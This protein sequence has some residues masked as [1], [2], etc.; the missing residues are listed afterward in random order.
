[1]SAPGRL[2]RLG[3]LLMAAVAPAAAP[4]APIAAP[5]A[6]AQERLV[7]SWTSEISPTYE[8]WS[9]GDGLLQ[10]SP[11]GSD[12]VLVER[13][14]QFSIPIAVVV[15]LG[16]RWTFDVAGAY[17]AGRVRL[18]GADPSL[19]TDEYD[20]DGLT[21]LRIRATGR[22]AEGLLL[23]LGFNA[24]TG[25]RD[26]SAEEFSALRVLAAP[27]FGLRV[28]TLGTAVGGTAGL[29]L[30]RPIGDWGWAF[31]ASY[32]L[33]GT[34]APG[35]VLGIPTADP[36][37]FSPGDAVRISLGGDGLVGPHGMTVGLSGDFYTED[38]L[39]QGTTPMATQLGPIFTFDWQFRVA[40]PR[41]REL[42]F[43]A[44]D[45]YRTK[46]EREDASI[47]RSSGNYLDAGVRAV[48]PLGRRT[49]FLTGLGFRHQT[50][51]D[52]DD[53]I[54][55]ASL[56]SGGL[57]LGLRQDLGG[58]YALEPFVRGQIGEMESAGRS[59]DATA[60]GGGVTLGLRF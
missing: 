8:T 20:L 29:V 25:N 18:A 14:S 12:S 59:A 9:L 39:V 27:V 44:V 24:P 21:D 22:L 50:G 56:V 30:A 10:P 26:L 33:R 51:L 3:L 23:T 54:S 5:R 49:S 13:V 32:E 38:E 45:R 42:T 46:Y 19:G 58:G 40:A 4:S 55:A 1:M 2:F 16:E 43:Y 28:P 36:A 7:G 48:L 34:Y 37:D 31:G 57:T 52:S 47:P 6:S 60:I 53:T 11:S 17:A 35:V 41:F 15:P